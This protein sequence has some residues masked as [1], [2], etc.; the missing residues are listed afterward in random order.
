MNHSYIQN[1]K[2]KQRYPC[3]T[4]ERFYQNKFEHLFG[5]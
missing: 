1:V 3:V 4:N 5:K 2:S